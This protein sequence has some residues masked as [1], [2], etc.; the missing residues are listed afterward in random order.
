MRGAFG[1]VLVLSAALAT[2]GV[3]ATPRLAGRILFAS[4]EGST[5]ENSEIY[6]IRSDGSGR[7]ALSRNP[8]GGDR[9]ARWSP[10]GALI[11]YWS[12]RL[13]RGR[14]VSGLYVMRADGSGRR[15]LT[16]AVLAVDSSDLPSWS[17]DG[18]KLAFSAERGERRGI[19]TVRSNGTGLRALARTGVG[20]AWSPRGDRIAFGDIGGIRVV[21][22]RGGNV[23]RLT[24]GVNDGAPA[25]SP[26]GRTIAFVRS[27]V[28][29]V[30]Q[31]LYLV[32]AAGGR[33]RRIYGGTRGVEMGRD[34]QW[35][36]DG[37]R[38]AFEASG[39]VYVVRVRDRAV[40]RLRR[41][42][43]PSWSPDGRR[44]AFTLGSAVYVMDADGSRVRHVRT[45]R[46]SDFSDGPVW[47]PDGRTLLYA[48]LLAKSDLEIFVVD[49]DG[50][51][52]RQL[53]RNSVDDWGPAWS[54]NRR[55]IA[56]VRRR[57]I[58]LMAANGT[59]QHRLVPGV[60][61]SWSPGGVRLAF[62]RAGVVYT[63]SARGGSATRVVAGD[64]PA[65]SP[66]GAEIAFVRATRL[67]VFD[68]GTRSERAIVD[69][70]SSCPG[71]TSEAS[72][73]G[74]DWA[75]DGRRLLY[76]VACDDGRFISMSAEFVGSDGSGR[77]TVPVGEL[78]PSRLAWSPDGARVAYIPDDEMRRLGTVKLDGTGRTTVVRGTGGAAYIDPDW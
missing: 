78:Q 9:G 61:P 49:A 21:H 45:E 31:A 35:S 76:A 11:A 66:S 62:A 17:P 77:R 46:G 59:K 14:R 43:W 70:G 18:R 71:S 22:A 63:I 73:Y 54:P 57:A 5:L 64:S 4:E 58:W 19:W 39:A 38:L 16:P 41:G 44:I 47:S 33:P 36:P 26:G 56:F 32:P 6:S 24:R 50:S 12:E 67:L 75:A 68:L 60:Q 34:P 20:P 27:D 28:N 51:R 37:R 69:I 2:L 3:A 52:L 13:E 7:R 10:D 74:P 23:R 42:D 8:G 29:G 53:T 30:V 25:W 15:R 40:T 72:L 55:R 65:W 1:L 48:T